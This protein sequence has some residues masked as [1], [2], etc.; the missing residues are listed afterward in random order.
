MVRVSKEA[1]Y[2]THQMRGS[3]KDTKLLSYGHHQCQEP[4]PRIVVV[5]RE[6]ERH[7][8]PNSTLALAGAMGN[9]GSPLIPL[10]VGS[11]QGNELA[12]K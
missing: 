1:L 3:S 4:K 5:E 9:L 2:F 12:A 6:G 8:I 10:T 7:R 11:A